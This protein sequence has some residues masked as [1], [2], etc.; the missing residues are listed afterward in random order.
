MRWERCDRLSPFERI[1]DELFDKSKQAA[2]HRI[3]GFNQEIVNFLGRELAAN[4]APSG[5]VGDLL[6]MRLIRL[7]FEH[8]LHPGNLR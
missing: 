7:V 1:D 8:A 4:R 2:I 6:K 3:N 5:D